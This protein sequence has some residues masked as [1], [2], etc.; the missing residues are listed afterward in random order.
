M[1]SPI[2]VVRPAKVTRAASRPR[3]T[4]VSFGEGAANVSGP[5]VANSGPTVAAPPP[6][7]VRSFSMGTSPISSVETSPVGESLLGSIVRQPSTSPMHQSSSPIAGQGQ[8]Y[9]PIARQAGQAQQYSPSLDLDGTTV[10][11]E[12]IAGDLRI[13]QGIKAEV[14]ARFRRRLEAELAS[15][16]HA[17]NLTAYKKCNWNN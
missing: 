8:E 16:S 13:K 15:M 9:W 7:R 2:L 5:T 14:A 1:E 4:S 12:T 3:A 10:G 11:D 17:D 6:P